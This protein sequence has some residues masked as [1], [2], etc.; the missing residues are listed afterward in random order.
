M[1]KPHRLVLIVLLAMLCALGLG[2]ASGQPTARR[3]YLPIVATDT[4]SITLL[5]DGDTTMVT[6][7]VLPGTSRIIVTYIDRANGNRLHVTEDMGTALVEIPLPPE[8]AAP[9]APADSQHPGFVAPG[10]KQANGAT[11]A[12]GG[13]LKIYV[14]TRDTGDPTGPFKLKRFDMPVPVP[15]Q[16]P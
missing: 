15:P 9:A 7:Y 2:A 16:I 3:A 11:V 10:D 5:V 1:R 12:I 8:F 4:P 13:M 14:T 6:A